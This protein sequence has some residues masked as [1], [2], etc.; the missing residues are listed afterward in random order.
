MQ[1]SEVFIEVQ[2][3]AYNKFVGDFKA[4]VWINRMH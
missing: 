3:I 1:V 2:S 4:T